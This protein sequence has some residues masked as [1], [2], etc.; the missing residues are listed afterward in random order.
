LTIN[1]RIDERLR[2]V[3]QL[4]TFNRDVI[5]QVV[6]ESHYDALSPLIQNLAGNRFKVCVGFRELDNSEI[7]CRMKKSDFY[8]VSICRF[9]NDVVYRARSCN[10]VVDTSADETS[11]HKNR[12][13]CECRQFLNELDLKYFHGKL[14]Q[15]PD[16]PDLSENFDSVEAEKRKRGRPKGSKKK[17]VLCDPEIKQD[18]SEVDTQDEHF[19]DD[20]GIKS[21]FA[22][23][24]T[25]TQPQ[26]N[27]N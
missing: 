26:V 8:N 22:Q 5:D 1:C 9:S 12:R 17:N 3:A 25:T 15:P 4:L 19:P 14:T 11:R 21:E 10:F 13:C 27:N 16:P 7:F 23:Q 6:T 24:V 2:V 18:R 20:T